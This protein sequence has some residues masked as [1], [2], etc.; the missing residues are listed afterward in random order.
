[1]AFV[2]SSPSLSIASVGKKNLFTKISKYQNIWSYFD[3]F[4]YFGCIQYFD[5][6]LVFWIFFLEISKICSQQVFH[7]VYE[8][9][10]APVYPEFA[11]PTPGTETTHVFIGRKEALLSDG[12]KA[13]LPE[14][15]R[16]MPELWA[17][18][19]DKVKPGDA[20]SSA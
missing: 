14:G 16:G 18:L 8:N 9:G 6:S 17:S 2:F 10:L 19:V 1:M 13:V 12:A 5:T 15:M 20:G 4:N 7:L 3:I 11:P